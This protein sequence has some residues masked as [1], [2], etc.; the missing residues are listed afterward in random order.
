MAGSGWGHCNRR[1]P[2]DLVAWFH[3]DAPV[4]QIVVFFGMEVVFDIP[5]RAV[6]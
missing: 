5:C 3:F 2:D 6:A 1:R 4:L